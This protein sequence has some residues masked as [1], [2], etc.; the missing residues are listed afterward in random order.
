M[1]TSLTS[2]HSHVWLIDIYDSGEK[3]RN[4]LIFYL[5]MI[6]QCNSERNLKQNQN[7]IQFR[8][9]TL[10]PVRNAFGATEEIQSR[11]M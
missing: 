10:Q 4:S 6:G 1:F 11:L 8:T 5:L 9:K 7:V 2:L 3:T